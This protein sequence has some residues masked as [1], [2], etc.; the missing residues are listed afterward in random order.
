M[1]KILEAIAEKIKE[2]DPVLFYCAFVLIFLTISAIFT[3]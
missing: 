1:N 3:K 2:T